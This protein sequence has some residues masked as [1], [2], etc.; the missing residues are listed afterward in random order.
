LFVV[1]K[2]NCLVMRK[3]ALVVGLISVIS[4]VARGQGEVPVNMFTGNPSIEVPI[5]TI[6]G[7]DL[8]DN[9]RLV[10]NAKG[11]R[12]GEP[13]G[14]V[15]LGWSLDVG[16]SITREVR[17]L[18]DDYTGTTA[19]D[20]RRGWLYNKGATG[21]NV[22]VAT[23]PNTSDLSAGPSCLDESADFLKIAEFAYV[24]DTEPD[25]FSFSAGGISGQFVFDNSATPQIRLI[26][27]QDIKIDVTFTSPTDKRISY[28]TITNNVGVKYVFST[29]STVSLQT[30][31]ITTKPTV[32]YLKYRFQAFN[33]DQF[34]SPVLYT[35]EWHLGSVNS[36][37]GDVLSYSYY[38]RPVESQPTSI[39]RDTICVSVRQKDVS[40]F[41]REKVFLEERKVYKAKLKQVSS[42][43]G[44]IVNINHGYN[45]Y[46]GNDPFN[47]GNHDNEFPFPTN[48]ISSVTVSDFRRATSEVKQ[49]REFAFGYSG[50]TTN[51]ALGPEIR[52]F[53]VGVKE[54]NGATA[55]PPYKFDYSFPLALPGSDSKDID[56]WG[57]YCGQR[58]NTSLIP[59]IYVYPQ[60]S[61]SQRY[62]IHQIPSYA[63]Q[64]YGIDGSD[65][66]ANPNAIEVGTLNGITYPWGGRTNIVYESN[67]F[68]D[69]VA[70]TSYYGGGL[71]I[72]SFT[73]LDGLNPNAKIEKQFTYLDASG[74]SSGR[75]VTMPAFAMPAWEYRDTESTNEYSYSLLTATN[76]AQE[77]WEYLTVRTEAN[78]NEQGSLAEGIGYKMVK[79]ARPGSGYVTHEFE[80][81][82]TYADAPIGDWSATQDKFARSSLCPPM[83]INT[84]GGSIFP[85]APDP[86]YSYER[87][88]VSWKKEY[89]EQKVNGQN[90]LVRTTQTTYQYL[91]KSGA[92]PYKVWGFKF[93]KY[94]NSD[95]DIFFFGRYY[96]LTDVDKVLSSETVTTYDAASASKNVVETTNYYFTS[97]NH[98]LLTKIA[99]TLSDGTIY[100][101]YLKYPLDYGTIPAGT[102]TTSQMIA[103]L[104]TSFRN[105][106]PIEQYKTIKR[107]GGTEAVIS[108]SAM[109]FNDFGLN[110][111][112]P[113]YQFTWTA[114]SPLLLTSFTPSYIHPTTKKFTLQSGYEKV[115][116]Y[117]E[118]DA[119]AKPKTSLG[120]DRIPRSVTWGYYTSVPILTLVNTSIDKV[121]YSDFDNIGPYNFDLALNLLS[122]SPSIVYGTGRTGATAVFT[123]VKLTKSITKGSDKYIFSGW[124]GKAVT[125]MTIRVIVKSNNNTVYSDQTFSIKPVPN[126]SMWDYFEKEIPVTVPATTFKVEI[127][128]AQGTTP[129]GTGSGLLDDLAF[130]PSNSKL[131]TI[132]YN[133][134]NGPAASTVG[135]KTTFT[136]Y[137]ELGRINYIMDRDKNIIERKTYQFTPN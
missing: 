80:M 40:G 44:E 133:F 72:K 4:L 104:Q 38:E 105:G 21:V 48:L 3:T 95:N 101:N 59:K 107:V 130:Y 85:Y 82:A 120:L 52:F 50:S 63:G 134:P 17:G 74:N 8:S 103:I 43:S 128:F 81:P 49:F 18:P 14:V 84:A 46:H 137:D 61:A 90:V 113:K 41:K 98:K 106:N 53:L 92:T 42:L 37:T 71:R 60:L 109:W 10:Y 77:V 62:R 129:T 122:D 112:L 9:I 108:G 28:F 66:T 119:F 36:P 34:L 35:D 136:V 56:Y 23:L 111:V 65:R 89:S 127:T 73:Y 2:K 47:E 51:S 11:L 76:S 19:A 102:D 131:S 16:G 27:F 29:I 13:T 22:D 20:T 33:I 67:Q 83:E 96:L 117:L 45:Y 118:Y 24:F 57:Y 25:L 54:K 99:S 5:W 15:G 79:V 30:S 55:M 58:G 123:E 91:Y 114:A 124:W 135:D 100:A 86:N 132:H 126:G 64:V 97:A 93:D 110:K 70:A 12:V 7:H 94:P 78:L 69:P 87:G 68:Y 1:A 39:G 115:Q 26:P 31:K 125:E 88:L 121:A 32:E 75:A 116:T 6:K